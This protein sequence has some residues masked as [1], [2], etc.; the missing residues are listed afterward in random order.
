MHRRAKRITAVA[1]LSRTAGEELGERAGLRKSEA[2]H[3]ERAPALA[4]GPSPI[5][6]ERGANQHIA[7]GNSQPHAIPT[8]K[9][10]ALFSGHGHR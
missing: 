9:S 4:P 7:S 8:Q 10:E 1:P 6:W 5:S 2:H 3:L